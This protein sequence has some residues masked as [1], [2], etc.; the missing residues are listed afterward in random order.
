MTSTSATSN[1]PSAVARRIDRVGVIGAGVMGQGIAA[2]LASCGVDVL[3]VDIVSRDAPEAVAP[4]D[5]GY[6]KIRAKRNAITAAGLKSALKAKPALFQRKADAVR[7]EIGNLEDDLEALGAC[8]WIVEAVIERLDIKQAVFAKVDEHRG[9]HTIVSSNTSGIPLAAMAEGRSEGFKKHFVITHFFN[10]VRYMKLLEIVYGDDTDPA[11]TARMHDFCANDMGKGVV[12]AKDT[13]NFIANRIGVHGM[14]VALDVWL[15][16][17]YR[18]EDID[19]ICGPAMGR[20]KSAIFRTADVVGLDTFGHVARNCFDNLPDD[21]ER[22]IFE[23][24]TVLQKMIDNG[25]IGSKAPDKAGFYKKVGREI[26]VLNPETL[27]Y[28]SKNKTRFPSIGAAKKIDNVRERVRHLALA[29]DRAG[30]YAWKVLSRSLVYAANRLGEIADDTTSID[31]AMRWGFNW[32]LGPFELWDAIGVKTIAE[33]L[34]AE[35]REVPKVIT[36]MLARGRTAFNSASQGAQYSDPD[37]WTYWHDGSMRSIE[38]LPGI[39]LA[40]LEANDEVVKSN[41]SADLV[42]LGDDVL[43][44]RFTSKMNALDDQIITLGMEAL[45][46]LDAGKYKAMVI[47]ND[48]QNFSVGANL[49]FIGMLAKQGKWDDL[50]KAV[51]TFQGF[52]QSLKYSKAPIISAPHGMALGGGCEIA[53]HATRMQAAAETYMGLVEVGVGLIPGAGGCKEMT[54]RALAGVDGKMQI[55]RIPF[56]QKSFE[57]IALAKVATGAGNMAEMGFLRP[58]DGWS[59]NGDTRIADAKKVALRMVEDGYRP[60]LEADN[61]VLPG[62]D[63]LGVFEMA[64][65]SFKWGGYASEHDVVVGRQVAKVLCGG[66]KGGKLTEGKLLEIE[67]EGFMHLCGLEKTQQRIEHMLMTGKPLRN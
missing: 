40:K 28:E 63:G 29:D 61:L 47:A 23:L 39:N 6:E 42:D 45:E 56:L 10:P 38:A 20:P 7:V 32:D 18:I 15:K 67:R 12:Y 26:M 22:A 4:Q 1:G 34:T 44:L 35:G 55:D 21:E 50:E 17:G 16:D 43:C 65:Q 5:T 27:Q 25:Q 66:E 31:R 9:E 33:K 36:D 52:A 64:L 54:V 24:P 51:A 37:E 11:V 19:T 48:G 57:A 49:L 59:V 53:I 2:H 62:A 8:D 14:M 60:P 58:I 41:A 46:W 3:L 30:H 13:I